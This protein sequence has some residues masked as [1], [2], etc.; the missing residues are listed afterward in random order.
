MILAIETSCDDTCAA[1]LA[2]DGRR[3]LSNVVHTQ[4][5]HARYGGVVPE[6]AS[7]A[8]LERLDGVVEK[9][10]ADA[11]VDLDGVT[12]VAVTVRPG[13]IG[14]LLV[15]VSAAKGLAYA[16][17]LP[18]VPVDHLEG[19]V[20]AAYLA[21]PDLEPPFVALIASGGHTALY[22][23]DE[24]GMRLLGETLDDAAGEAL[25]KG[26]RMLGLGFP[27][28]PEI[29]RVAQNGDPARH[30]FPVGLRDKNNLDFSF[31]GL[32]TSLL[33]KLKALDE[34]GAREELPHLAAGYEA[35]V[36][37]ALSRKLL[38]AA[39]AR[40]IPTVVAAGGVAANGLLRRTLREEC[41]RRGL[42]LV[43]PPPELCTDNAAMIGAAA[44]LSRAVSFPDYLA[45]N[46]RS[47]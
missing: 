33:Y 12:S 35:A 36:V 46:A 41:D 30:D 40:N 23:V 47:V 10:L 3:A 13:L 4:T 22:F 27:G 29:S 21:E 38:R 39:D 7:R 26:A 15:G 5:E 6:V 8:H 24:D 31:S 19:H 25:D 16:R 37:E 44:P 34:N 14:A 2:P 17:R 28:G 42:R 9:A 18:L 11:D 20:A 45:L 43:V 1:V 32:K